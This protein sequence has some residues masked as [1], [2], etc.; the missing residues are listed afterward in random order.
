MAFIGTLCLILVLTALA[1]HLCRRIGIPGVV[2]QLLVGLVVGTGGLQWIHSDELIHHFSEIGVI[3]LM[4]LAGLESDMALLRKYFK[5]GMLVAIFGV[6]FPLLLGTGG[7]FAFDVT[8]TEAFFL[9]VVLAATSVSISV[10]V[11]KEL[12]AVNT[13]EGST[14]LGASV[15]D[16]ILIVLVLSI[17]LTFLGGNQGNDQS[18]GITLLQQ[19]IYFVLIYLLVKWIAPY[20]MHLSERIYTTASVIIMSLVICLAMSYVADF[21]GLSSVIGA[22]FAGI[23]VGQT[24]VKEQVFI[25]VESIGYAIFIPVFFVNIG[26]E[27]ELSSIVTYFPFILAFVVI[28]VISKLF[29]GYLGSKMAGFSNNSAWMVGAGMI[30]RG[31]MALIVLQIGSQGGLIPERY[32]APM[33]ITILISTL[34]SPLILKYFAKK[35]LAKHA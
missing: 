31:E 33:V 32:F 29:G 24:K 17:S 3:L 7:G 27:V 5:P 12:Q 10:E 21:V 23:A 16:D 11:L 28:A 18:I 8:K 35:V 15:V 9:G 25:N 2:G 19:G 1:A 4:F 20:L 34:V 26:L 14:I 13:K 30:S 22:F 6:I